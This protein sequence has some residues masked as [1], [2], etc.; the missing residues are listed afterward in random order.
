VRNTGIGK[1]DGQAFSP[2]PIRQAHAQWLRDEAHGEAPSE[3]TVRVPKRFE[4]R[5]RRAGLAFT[6]V[7]DIGYAKL[8]ETTLEM[9]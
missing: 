1:S 3:H 4:R 9:S 6:K 7:R 2:D 8:I 5:C